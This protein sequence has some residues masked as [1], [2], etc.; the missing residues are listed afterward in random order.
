ML[1]KVV[2]ALLVFV[3]LSSA[4]MPVMAASEVS[5]EILLKRAVL[6]SLNEKGKLQLNVMWINQ[7][8][9]FG[10]KSC[11]SSCCSCGNDTCPVIFYSVDVN[12][13]YNVSKKGETLK[14]LNVT[15]YNESFSYSLYML[16]YIVEREQYN[17]TVITRTMPL[18]DTNLFATMVNIDP[19]DDKAKP[20]ADVVFFTNKTT[21]AEHYRLLGMVLNDVRRNDNTS[22]IWNKVR[23]ELNDLAKRVERDLGEYNFEGTGWVFVI[24]E[25]LVCSIL[26]SGSLY[27]NFYCLQPRDSNWVISFA[28]CGGLA[29]VIAGCVLNCSTLVGCA[30]CLTAGVGYG[31]ITC[32]YKCPAMKLCISA[33]GLYDLHCVRLW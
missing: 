13:V 24:D 29:L 11:T 25:T 28:C 33:L 12:E 1:R 22:W 6:A 8:I 7:T 31:L 9:N 27:A 19:R 17:L 4:V 20:V 26:I 3:M 30:A 2:S 16:S 5:S 18:S 21:L 15:V 14:L 23:I 10:N 32:K